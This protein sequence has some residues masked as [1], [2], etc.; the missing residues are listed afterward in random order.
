MSYLKY[1]YNNITY[2]Q[3]PGDNGEGL[4]TVP[5]IFRAVFKSE[6]FRTNSAIRI[7]RAPGFRTN[8]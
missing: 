4:A 1:I 8:T 7:A 5:C 2:V 3:G 6:G